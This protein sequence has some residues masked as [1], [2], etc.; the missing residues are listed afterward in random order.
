MITVKGQYLAVETVLTVGMAI[1]I[2]I[3]TITLFTSYQDEVVSTA[4]ANQA[5]I[6]QARLIESLYTLE[7]VDNGEKEVDLP[8]EIGGDSYTI[9]LGDDLKI[10]S[11]NE[12][13]TSD[14][15][16]LSEYEF[17][18]ST[19]GGT[20]KIFKRGNKFRLEEN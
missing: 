12:E 5:D 10:T 4:G 6:V 14:L 18:G 7:N 13:R 8:Q 9:A 19:D 16:Q 15:D 3:G 20:V 1:T 17:D 11:N 2:A